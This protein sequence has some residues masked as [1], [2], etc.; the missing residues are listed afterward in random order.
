MQAMQ[1]APDA[2]PTALVASVFAA[3]STA[4]IGPMG[5]RHEG[6]PGRIAAWPELR[7]PSWPVRPPGG[8]AACA[9]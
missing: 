2:H 5:A 7:L 6:M 9:C 3:R 4:C 8:T 1:A